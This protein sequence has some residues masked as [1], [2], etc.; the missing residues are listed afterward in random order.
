MAG[1]EALGM[2]VRFSADGSWTTTISTPREE[3]R[4]ALPMPVLKASGVARARNAARSTV[5]TA[6]VAQRFIACINTLPDFDANRVL[7]GACNSSASASIS[8]EFETEGVTLGWNK[9]NTML[10]PSA[11]P[12]AIGT[13]VSAAVKT[14]GATISFLNDILGMGA[15]FEYTYTNFFHQR[16]DHAF[17]IAA[18]ELSPPQE[19]VLDKLGETLCIATDGGAGV[20]LSRT[21]PSGVDKVWRFALCGR[22]SEP[23]ALTLPEGW[24]NAAQLNV[25]L[26]AAK[27]MLSSLLFPY[28]LQHLLHGQS[29]DKAILNIS[30]E[31]RSGFVLGF[32]RSGRAA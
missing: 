18:E 22:Q 15:A 29:H 8:W 32:E 19:I 6:L 21:K 14:H 3:M 31:G 2:P 30:I 16:A 13:Q 4:Q 11:L 9:T 7:I 27:A 23:G 5:F 1:A 24:N 28:A 17:I 26:P 10:M 25:R 20:L 12:S